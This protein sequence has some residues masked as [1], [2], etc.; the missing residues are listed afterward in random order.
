VAAF[1]LPGRVNA[2]VDE[3]RASGQPVSTHAV[4]VTNR[5]AVELAMVDVVA[6]FGTPTILEPRGCRT[7]DG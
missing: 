2:T 7:R 5:A 3:L 6:R 1:D 4:D